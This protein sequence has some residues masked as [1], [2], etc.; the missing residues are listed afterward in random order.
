MNVIAIDPGGARKKCA[1]VR[2]TADIIDAYAI[3]VFRG[4]LHVPCALT[5][6]VIVER[7][8]QDGRSFAA[9]PEDLIE[10]AWEGAM[11]AAA[12]AWDSGATLVGLT[13]R[14]WK[15]TEPK[16]QMHSRLWA[17]LSDAERATL[18]GEA[19]RRAIYTAREKGAIKRWAPHSTAYY[20]R[21]FVMADV[22]DA[23]AMAAVF[24][25]RLQKRG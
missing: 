3:E 23:A 5:D 16:S 1:T 10:I 9:R 7:P 25:G 24:V 22:L 2:M 8:Q 20:P 13:P 19:T 17:V 15:G 4:A 14:E 11:L 12:Y 18:G 6:A 21:S